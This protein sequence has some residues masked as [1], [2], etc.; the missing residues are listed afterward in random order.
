[1]HCTYEENGDQSP[2]DLAQFFCALAC[3]R[4]EGRFSALHHNDDHLSN[5]IAGRVIDN[6]FHWLE[7]GIQWMGPDE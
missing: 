3:R 5:Q 1:M 4:I 6:N 7:K 2:I